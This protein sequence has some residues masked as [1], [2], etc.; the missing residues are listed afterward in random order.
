VTRAVITGVGA[1]SAF[2]LG[3]SQLWNGLSQGQCA[4]GP[5]RGFDASTFPTQ[6]A[7]EVPI[8]SVSASWLAEHLSLYEASLPRFSDWQAAGALR[9][10]KATF[11]MLAAAEAW[12]RAGCGPD[13][14]DAW[15]SL[16]TGL[17]QGFLE[18]FAT[19]FD[20][21]RVDWRAEVE[22][23][24]P[25]MR[26]RSPVEFPGRCVSELLE[27]RGRSIFNVSACAAGALAVAHAAALIE[28]GSASIVLCGGTDS[29]INPLAFGGMS[30]I[31][32]PSP[33]NTRDA[34]RP[35]DRRRD[36]LVIG[37]GA[38]LFVIEAE[39]RAQAR[40][41]KPLAR[42][43]GWGSSQD[44][45]RPTAPLPDGSAAARAM[46]RALTRAKLD[47]RDVG[48]INAH[49]TGTPLNDPAEAKAIRNVFGTHT[50]SIPTSSIKGAVGHLMVAS[51][52]IEIAASLLCFQ[53]DLLPGTANHLERD[54]E[55]D[56]DV[57]GETP[58]AAAVDVVLSNSFGFGGQNAAII[59]GRVP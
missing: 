10:R 33:R 49:G 45:Y 55:C 23:A 25:R 21:H 50:D 14:K 46:A 27:L 1:V 8:G 58:R 47:A 31:G 37:E 53:R 56:L 26:F 2:G 16:A 9:D 30:R 35:F 57:I 18:D 15:L 22:M 17:E 39:E 38:A 42:V 41:A 48:Y 29:L 11:A 59:L 34:C 32:A 6:V 36:G 4:I 5:I 19:L 43:L 12:K 28:R 24:L 52:A 20:N 51:G 7:G 40:G 44:A 13:E 54:P 3:V